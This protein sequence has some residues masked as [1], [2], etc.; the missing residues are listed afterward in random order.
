MKTIKITSFLLAILFATGC[1]HSENHESH[2]GDAVHENH[3]DEAHADEQIELNN[4]EKWTVNEEMIPFVEQSVQLMEE[5]DGTDYKQLADGLKDNNSK[6]IKSCTMDGKSH[7][8]LHKWLHPHLDLVKALGKAESQ[9]EADKIVADLNQ[10][11][12]TYNT[13]FQ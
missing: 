13:Y 10:S 5:Y 7:D 9:E 1:N 6:L 12:E 2:N 8:E 4:G 11:F 3:N